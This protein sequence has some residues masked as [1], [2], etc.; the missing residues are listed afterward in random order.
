MNTF[1]ANDMACGHC[2][3]TIRNALS[4]LDPAAKVSI[5]VSAR[6]VDVEKASASSARLQGV[7]AA[8]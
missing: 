1:Q 2:A 4:A 7:A 8:E 6:C 3:A 5:D